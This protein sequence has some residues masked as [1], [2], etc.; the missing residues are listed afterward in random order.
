[1]SRVIAWSGSKAAL[2][3]IPAP[4]VLAYERSGRIQARG[5]R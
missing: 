5:R 2:A 4:G 1:M 3:E